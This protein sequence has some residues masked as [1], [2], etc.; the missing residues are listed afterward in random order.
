M[1]RPINITKS[2]YDD[3]GNVVYLDGVLL[4]NN[5]EVGSYKKRRE[6]GEVV[7]DCIRGSITVRVEQQ[8]EGEMKTL[9]IPVKFFADK[10]TKDN[11]I[12]PSYTRLNEYMTT[13]NSAA[14]VGIENADRVNVGGCSLKINYGLESLPIDINGSFIN[15]RPKANFKEQAVFYL[16]GLV[17]YLDEEF[18]PVGGMTTGRYKL[19]LGVPRYGGDVDEFNIV[20]SSPK[21][22]EVVTRSWQV[23][24]T[25]KVA[26]KLNF[27]TSVKSVAMSDFGDE[28]TL[29]RHLETT[30]KELLCTGGNEI[31]YSDD[32]AYDARE[33]KLAM[34][35]TKSREAQK[36]ESKKNTKPA[37]DATKANI[38]FG[39]FG[40][41]GFGKDS[42]DTF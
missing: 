37:V 28:D 24:D 7:M 17:T 15:V 3:Y 19:K 4:E 10:Y 23:G 6:T 42:F 20:I 32:V 13:L 30:V 9:E 25:V 39:G 40:D 27:S 18:D 5:L 31:P 2:N 26:G 38:G 33:I 34:E 11:K 1:I 21:V 12:N 36:R 29:G 14:V 35:N 41:F 22:I 16:N 8:I